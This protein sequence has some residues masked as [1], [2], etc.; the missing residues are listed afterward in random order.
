MSG[1]CQMG[2]AVWGRPEH[3]LHHFVYSKYDGG[4]LHYESLVASETR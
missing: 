2:D 4:D 1:V 3:K